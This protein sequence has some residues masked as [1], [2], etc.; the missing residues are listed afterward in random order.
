ML[1]GHYIIDK[2][3]RKY[4]M[5]N[6]RIP[7]YRPLPREGEF[8]QILHLET[9]AHWIC[10]SGNCKPENIIQIHV[11]DSKNVNRVNHELISQVSAFFRCHN[12]L[13]YLEFVFHKVTYQWDDSSCGLHS[14]ANAIVLCHNGL[15]EW[16]YFIIKDMREHLVSIIKNGDHVE[17]FPMIL[18]SC[19]I[20][21][22][23]LK[24]K[25]VFCYCRQE[26]DKS[27][28]VHCNR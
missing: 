24:V 11:Y 5:K 22:P 15:P 18:I 21:E 28:M 2:N 16:H 27:E 1:R 17:E 20:H 10:I 9:R 26:D 7:R 19:D 13:E 12:N 3:T 4:D 8:I 23:S 25:P 14:I 6:T